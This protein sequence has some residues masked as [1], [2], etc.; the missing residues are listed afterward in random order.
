LENSTRSG[1]LINLQV[2]VSDSGEIICCI[3]FRIAALHSRSD[4]ITL[5]VLKRVIGAN[6]MVS[7]HIFKIFDGT[8]QKEEEDK[9]NKGCSILCC[10]FIASLLPLS[11]SAKQR[12]DLLRE[13]ALVVIPDPRT[14]TSGDAFSQGDSPVDVDNGENDFHG[15]DKGVPQHGIATP[16]LAIQATAAVESSLLVAQFYKALVSAMENAKDATPEDHHKMKQLAADLFGL[17]Q[18]VALRRPHA[19]ARLPPPPHT[20]THRQHT[21][22]NTRMLTA[23]TIS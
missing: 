7:A 18:P 3:V 23:H 13:V 4:F 1:L 9:L 21:L 8:K 16:S 12:E 19:R 6:N 14:G 5:E 20:H 17:R 22:T 15:E 2:V 10:L 11:L